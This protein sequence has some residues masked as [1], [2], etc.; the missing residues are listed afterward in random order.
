MRSEVTEQNPYW[1]AGATAHAIGI[2]YLRNPF[3]RGKGWFS[4]EAT[5]WF[6][7]W[8]WARNHLSK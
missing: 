4:D 5:E 6:A 8:W 2:P 7:G 3:L 1:H